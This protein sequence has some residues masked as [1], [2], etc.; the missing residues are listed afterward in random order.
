MWTACVHTAVGMDSQGTCDASAPNTHPT[1]F[2]VSVSSQRS[3]MGAV[4]LSLHSPWGSGCKLA[5]KK[6][7]RSQ[8][9]CQAEGG[10]AC[11]AATVANPG[12]GR[13]KML[14]FCHRVHGP[15]PGFL[16]SGGCVLV[17]VTCLLLGVPKVTGP[18][19]F[20]PSSSRWS[21]RFSKRLS[22]QGER[23]PQDRSHWGEVTLACDYPVT[24]ELTSWPPLSP[25]QEGP[26]H[27]GGHT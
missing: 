3:R 6:G 13:T 16:C 19:G 7:T 9:S 25:A 12:V 17:P 27:I 14:G 18:S 21:L 22:S 5:P 23:I 10:S 11:L 15:G 8:E 26:F 1:R 4:F 20:L 2:P 24:K